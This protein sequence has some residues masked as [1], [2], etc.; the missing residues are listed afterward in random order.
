[1]GSAKELIHYIK[2]I[3]NFSGEGHFVFKNTYSVKDWKRFEEQIPGKG[4]SLCLF[5]AKTFEL[6][7]KEGIPTIYMGLMENEKTVRL[8]ELENPTN[9]MR[10]ETVNVPELPVRKLESGISYD[11]KS[12]NQEKVRVV[13]LEWIFRY[14][15]PKGSSVR[16]RMKPIELGFSFSE[17]PDHNLPLRESRIECST[18]YESEDR[19]LN[20]QEALSISGLSGEEFEKMKDYTRKI[21]DIITDQ[22]KK[23][24]LT[25]EDGKVEFA[26]VNGEILLGD[27]AGTPDEDRFTW[28]GKEGSKEILRQYYNKNQK[29][30]CDYVDAAKKLARKKGI[31]DWRDLCLIGPEKVP[32]KLLELVGEAYQAGANLYTE[33]NFFR[34][35]PL[36]IVLGEIYSE[37]NV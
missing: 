6:V 8:D 34:T 9:E 36:E 4:E 29:E 21:G 37:F 31:E 30:W 15:I 2:P 12:Y 10:I 22:C 27:V 35:R 25:H 16:K 19:Y 20:E 17:W 11:Y 14:F 13:P 7:E 5:A 26:Y 24:G 18:K 1:M 28:K 32:N 33:K 23:V 3:K